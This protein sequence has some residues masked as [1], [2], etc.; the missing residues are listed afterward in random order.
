MLYSFDDED[1]PTLEEIF[2]QSNQG[3]VTSYIFL[4]Q[5]IEKKI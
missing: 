3:D 5:M 2:F 4:D 1:M